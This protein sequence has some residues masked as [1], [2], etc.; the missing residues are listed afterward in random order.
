MGGRS[1][2]KQR[3]TEAFDELH[4]ALA[5]ALGAADGL[6]DAAVRAHAETLVEQ[7]LRTEGLD[8]ARADPALAVPLA[9]PQLADVVARVEA[10]RAAAFDPWLRTG[11][12]ALA[13][14][15]E[16]AAPLSAGLEPG[17]WLGQ[18]G[19]ADG[20]EEVP[21]LWRIGQGR[22]GQ[23]R[24]GQARIGPATRAAGKSLTPPVTWPVGVPLLDESHLQITSTGD[25][26]AQAEA[27]VET[28]LMRVVSHFTPGLVRLHVWD[29]GQFTGV[30]PGLYPLTRSGLLT[31]HDP[32][33]LSH[34]LEE[35]SD[36]IRRVHT[37]LL[38]DGHPTLA[39]HVAAT[40]TR[41]KPWIVTV[42]V[43]DGRPLADEDHWQ[44]QRISRGGLASGVSL[45][46][47]DVPVTLQ[48][49]HET[50][51]LHDGGAATSSMTGE[52]VVVVPDPPLPRDAVTRAAHVLADAHEHGHAR[53][54]ADLL[55]GPGRW[56]RERSV[57]GLRAPIGFADGMPLDVVLADESPHALIGGPSGTGKTNL[58]LTMISSMAARYD[59]DELELYLLDFKEGVSFAQFTRGRRDTTWL[60][61]AR[62]VG[63]NINTDRE[64]GLALLQFLADEMRRRAEAAKDHE[65]TKLEE[66]RGADPDGRWPRIVAVIDEFQLL[67]AERDDVT[68]KATALLEDVARRGRS[69]GIHLVLAS[70]DV[71]GIEAFWGRPAV[72]EQFVLRIALP[73]ARRVLGELNEA[74][75]DLPRWHA[76]VNHDSGVRHGNE[77]VRIPDAT[78]RGT[79]DEVQRVLHGT[80]SAGRPEPVLFDGSRAPAVADLLPLLPAGGPPQAL[81]GQCIDVAGRPA[82]AA[83]ADTPGRNV[84]VLGADA[85]DAGRVI[86]AAAGSLA[87]QY[88]PGS[89]D[90]V[91][92]PLLADARALLARFTAA[93][94][95]PEVVALDGVRARVEALAADVVAR[96]GGAS[97][98]PVLLVLLG[99]DAADPVLEREGI[100]ALRR[101]LR[102]GPETGVHVLGWWRSVAR[103]RSTLSVSAT[104]DDVGAWVALDVQGSELGALV[105]GMMLS[106]SPRPG[107]GLFYDRAQ[108]SR[109]EVVIVPSSEEP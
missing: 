45:V 4:G 10:D 23:G 13:E 8:D 80:W 9:N 100:E 58:L 108:H 88:P 28:L 27:L 75:M 81:L 50:V 106:W 30:V 107:R 63:V 29:V 85:E 31:V 103:L 25:G 89:V 22:I 55:P 14:L 71:S 90:V 52:H 59:P 60:P 109:P 1:G 36:R 20:I 18:V 77:V 6:Q 67:F 93:G 56:G 94:H 61:H 21:G 44:L 66:L 72:F 38:I 65:V 79:T 47:V 15:L 46:L 26:R 41:V 2:R 16:R 96:L 34:L 51:R 17:R 7:W 24:I 54:F 82:T 104:P 64:F 69:Q 101:V 62:L 99:A 53:A 76:I 5:A 105:P 19:K 57:T 42:L 37:R 91:V 83:L 43:G 32:G 97:R 73:R 3:I 74:A 35:L 84:A 86:G 40:G 12:A 92:A 102:S 49:P 98:R 39:S 78:A 48:A 33:R 70:Q 95:A 68:K 87:G 11:P